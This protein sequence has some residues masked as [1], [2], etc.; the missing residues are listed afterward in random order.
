MIFLQKIDWLWR[1]L[2]K[3]YRLVFWDVLHG[4]NPLKFLHTFLFQALKNVKI[5]EI[6]EFCSF[7]CHSNLLIVLYLNR[8][9]KVIQNIKWICYYEMILV[10]N[11]DVWNIKTLL[12]NLFRAVKK[13]H[14]TFQ[15]YFANPIHF[16][17]L[18]QLKSTAWR[19]IVL[20]RKLI[21]II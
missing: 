8:N 7:G 11:F 9:E 1:L 10:N 4:G 21:I 5:F 15:I 14:N 3:I 13:R 16:D 6:P 20:I 19:L 2:W 17:I 12:F 18:V